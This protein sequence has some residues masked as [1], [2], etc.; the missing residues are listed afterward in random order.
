MVLG[1]FPDYW[2][3]TSPGG[4]VQNQHHCWND[5]VLALHCP[6]QK[7]HY[8]CWHSSEPFLLSSVRSP[9]LSRLHKILALLRNTLASLVQLEEIYGWE[10]GSARWSNISPHENKSIL[11]HW[12]ERAKAKRH[13]QKLKTPLNS[14]YYSIS[15]RIQS[16]NL[17]KH[18]D[19]VPQLA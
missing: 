3:R 13:E 14:P 7:N 6:L 19:R 18:R 16:D 9:R 12:R 5:M 10:Q 4:T 17:S 2:F 15:N 8:P 1:T 11:L